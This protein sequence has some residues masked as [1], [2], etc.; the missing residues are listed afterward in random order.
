VD[1]GWRRHGIARALMRALASIALNAG[2]RR[3]Q[4]LV[5]PSNEPALRFYE[6]LGAEGAQDWLVMQLRGDG[7]DRLVQDQTSSMGWDLSPSGG[8]RPQESSDRAD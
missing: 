1:L 8:T 7:L 4:W 2:C 5:L 6:S 3:F